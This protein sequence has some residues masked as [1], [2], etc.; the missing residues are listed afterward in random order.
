ME[1]ISAEEEYARFVWHILNKIKEKL[2]LQANKNEPLIYNLF[3]HPQS[4]DWDKPNSTTEQQLLEKLKKLGVMEEAVERTPFQIGKENETDNPKSAGISYYFKINE[5]VFNKYYGIY[6][7]LVEQY[8]KAD[9]Q[10]NT[11]IFYENG[12]IKYIDPSGKEYQAKLK[13]NTNSYRL[14]KFLVYKPRQV[15]EFGELAKSL[16]KAR[17]DVNYSDDER[18]VRDTVQSIKDKLKY[19]GDDLFESDNGFGLKCDVLIKK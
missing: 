16:K 13:S 8:D 2:L 7:K 1:T 11:L 12:E 15:F 17:S 6:Q 9:K 18:R 3:L 19:Y 4:K 10:G 14:L 5:A